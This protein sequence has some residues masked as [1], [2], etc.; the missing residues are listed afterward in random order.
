MDEEREPATGV[1]GL[2]LGV[3]P[4][5]Q[6]LRSDSDGEGC[7]SAKGERPVEGG[8]IHNDRP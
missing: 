3:V 4:N 8:F 1:D 7:D 6:H 5:E 2:E